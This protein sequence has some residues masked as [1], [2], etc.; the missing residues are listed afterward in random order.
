MK[1]SKKTIVCSLVLLII[2]LLVGSTNKYFPNVTMVKLRYE[3]VRGIA[4]A[5]RVYS[6]DYDTYLPPLDKWCDKLIDEAGCGAGSFVGWI[7]KEEGKCG[8]ALNEN[9]AGLKFD[10]LDDKVVLAFEAKGEWNLS[11]GI[12]LARNTKQKDIAVVFVD[13]YMDFVKLEDIDNLKWEP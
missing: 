8:Y 5:L 12:N 10:E 2:L 3:G 13:G 9:L 11:G 1:T 7:E 6:H 4:I